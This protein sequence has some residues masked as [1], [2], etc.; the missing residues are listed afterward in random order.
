MSTKAKKIIA[1][2][3]LVVGIIA[4]TYAVNPWNRQRIN[5]KSGLHQNS[6]DAKLRGQPVVFNDYVYYPGK[7]GQ[8]AL[9][10][11]EKTT[12]IETKKYD[13]GTMVLGINGVKPDDKHFWKLYYNGQEAQVGADQLITHDGDAVEWILEA[14]KK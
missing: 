1:I 12:K 5:Y 13:F 8:N 10:L 14:I 6:T 4:V 7:E 3:V 2:V 9:E 11:L